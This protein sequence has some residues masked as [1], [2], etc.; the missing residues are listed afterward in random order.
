LP[1]ER[2]TDDASIVASN[3]AGLIK[4][5]PDADTLIVDDLPNEFGVPN[6]DPDGT[7]QVDNHDMLTGTNTQGTLYCPN[8][9]A[10]CT[11]S[12]WTNAQPTGKPRVGHSWPRRGGGGSGGGFGGFGG[13]G[14]G[15]GGGGLGSINNWMSSLDEAGCAPGV[16]LIEMG[17]PQASNPTVGSGG[18]YGGFYCFALTP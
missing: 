2:G 3:L 11:C 4:E 13:F 17:P 8:D 9:P 5:R 10:T 15:I 6:H 18:G 7:G 12:D 14:G 1:A 16:S